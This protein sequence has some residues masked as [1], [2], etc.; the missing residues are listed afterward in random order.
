MGNEFYQAASKMDD[1]ELVATYNDVLSALVADAR[2]ENPEDD[3]ILT[4]IEDVMKVRHQA[5][6]RRRVDF[7]GYGKVFN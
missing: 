2:A 3:E 6:P 4:A 5:L 7:A 1:R